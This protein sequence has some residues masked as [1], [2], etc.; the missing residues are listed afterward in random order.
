MTGNQNNPKDPG[1]KAEAIKESELNFHSLFAAMTEGVAIH[2]MIYDGNGKAVDYII[3]DVNPSFEKNLGIPADK[4]KGAH[5]SKLFGLTPP[6][7]IDIY[8]HVLK[9]KSQGPYRLSDNLSSDQGYI[10]MMHV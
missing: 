5:G 2:Q 3:R 10:V 1:T 7:Y 8:E 9:R 6:P 4:A